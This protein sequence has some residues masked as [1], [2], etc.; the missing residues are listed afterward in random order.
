MRLIALAI[1]AILAALCPAGI[2]RGQNNNTVVVDE[3]LGA[4]YSLGMTLWHM[5][6]NVEMIARF[7]D[8]VRQAGLAPEK[9][10]PVADLKPP[11]S[12]VRILVE[13][14]LLGNENLNGWKA[15]GDYIVAPGGDGGPTTAI[16]L[17]V[18]RAGLYRL[19]VQYHARVG[20]RGVTFM[21]IYRAG[22]EELGPVCQPDELY[23]MP[24]AVTGPAWKDMLV[25]L[26]AGELIIK[27]GP[28][29]NVWHG[30]GSYDQRQVDCLYLTDE[31]WAE[32]PSAD[33]RRAMREAKSP[34]GIQWIVNAP[35]SPA[36]I[37]TWRW[38]QVRPLSWEEAGAN[39]RLFDLSRRFW[40]ETVDKLSLQEYEEKDK[41]DYRLPER[42][43]IYND[44][45]NMVANLVRARRQIETLNADI[46][47]RELGYRYV[48][49]DV[50]GNIDGLRADTR[51]DKD[52]PYAR[53]GGWF[54]W[55]HAGGCLYASYGASRGT[56]TT[57]VPVAEPG[58]Y[59]V[60]VL[61]NPVNLSYTAPWYGKVSVD[62]VEQFTYH[63]AGKISAVWMKMGEAVVQKPGRVQVDFILDGA[64]SG[65]TDRRIYTLFLV[66]DAT[67]LPNGTVRPPW[68]MDMYRRRAA[69]AG[70]QDKD[71]LLLWLS[72]DPYRPL[73]QEV[74]ADRT[75]AGDSWPHEPIRGT[76]RAKEMLMARDTQAAVQVGLRNLTDKP[77]LL[78]VQ[79][80]PLRG[81]GGVFRGAVTW[82]TEA[83]VPYGA[84]RQ[85]WTPFFLMRRP[86][87]T[88]PPLN[89]AGVWLTV[90]TRQVPPGDYEVAVIFR[91]RGIPA[92]TVMLKV[93]ISAVKPEPR[94]PVLVNGWTRP[95]EGE[96]YL[97]D[98]VEHGMNVWYV[99]AG[100]PMSKAD[101]QKWGIRQLHLHC[102]GMQGIPEWLANLK[103]LG[104][105]YDDYFIG[106][107]DE[108]NAGT[109][110]KLKPYLEIAEEIR[111]ADPKVRISFNPAE[112]ATLATFQILDKYCDFWLPY[113]KHV[114]S[115]YY[116]NPAKRAL[117]HPKP[118]MWYT[119][120]CLWDKTA[121][122]PGIRQVPSQPGNCVGVAF[123][124]LNYPW[125]DQWDTGYE[126]ISDASTMGAVISRHG[127]VATIVW[128]QIREVLQ[129][130]NLAM[131]VR[132]RLG[133][134]TF[135]EVTDTDMQR[136]IR[137]GTSAELIRW[138]ETH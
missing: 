133:V 35:L 108:P 13:P 31:L 84:D 69:A 67:I 103:K 9:L 93:R 137:E 118:W 101:M 121:R 19:W 102:G 63:H 47:R 95:H 3:P 129:T 122:D 74:W 26:P 130:A 46:S 116:D 45:W 70:A 98:F 4:R 15:N 131:M 85:Q 119:T 57:W 37:D 72:E 12:V 22:Q 23:D 75:S 115:P 88:V 105:K 77:L 109:E 120:P 58:T 82:R 24:P 11:A 112:E 25:D 48:W 134:R 81:K 5:G 135:N 124:A 41:P 54:R 60:W 100:S 56:V 138:L 99:H 42:Q 68:T 104:L 66:N 30:K 43:V 86:N 39:P 53:Y 10:L 29:L 132:E 76:V 123:F 6:H 89:V 20:G 59:T 2:A 16:S 40:Q 52:G 55:S 125:R 90:D 114:F 136:L 79:P 83:F 49:H 14:E 64:G 87:I 32:P 80:G 17:F 34:V 44:T 33:I 61:S 27:F 91:G 36:D 28:V 107:K 62:G 117:Y 18:P 96:A 111:K 127:P 97:R 65:G 38:W 126:H 51:Y 94:Q 110:E 78:E 21:K 50:A 113:T 71:K 128:E 106:I 1:A 73:S 8:Y 7:H 92:Y